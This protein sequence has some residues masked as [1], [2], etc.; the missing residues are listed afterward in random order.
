MSDVPATSNEYL[1]VKRRDLRRAAIAIFVVGALWLMSS[2][3][4]EGSES[5]APEDLA[6]SV[7]APFVPQPDAP[8]FVAEPIDPLA[9]DELEPDAAAPYPGGDELGGEYA[10]DDIAVWE[11]LVRDNRFPEDD[12]YYLPDG[13]YTIPEG[14]GSFS[15]EAEVG[16]MPLVSGTIDQ[17]GEGNSVFSVD[18]EVLNLP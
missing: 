5:N 11:N 16:G 6:F 8:A 12:T 18:G 14:G 17:S 3:S 9:V 2:A 4:D 13:S 7:D 10:P 15:G 1:I